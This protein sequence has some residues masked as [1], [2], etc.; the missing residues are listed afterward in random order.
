MSPGVRIPTGADSALQFGG[1]LETY[2][3]FNFNRP[4]NGITEFRAFDNRHNTFAL[5]AA[6][7]DIGWS[8]RSVAARLVLQA[9][10][11][12]DTYYAASEPT[13]AG[14]ALTP[15]ST[16]AAIRFIQQATL[17]WSPVPRRWTVDAGLFLSPIG[18]ESMPTHQ[19]FT[20]S[21]SV[22]FFALPFYHAGARVQWS[23]SPA[24]ALRL[25]VY[26]GWNNA[27]DNNR[28]KTLG[29]D[30][31]YTPSTTVSLGAAYFS[32]VERPTGAPEG[33]AWRHLLDVFVLW[34]PVERVHLL[35]DADVG[36]E[37]NTFGFSGWA[38]GNGA[39]RA[40]LTSWLYTAVRATVFAE[41]RASKNGVSAAPIAIPAGRIASGSLTLEA[42]PE[43]QVSF[44]LELRRD[45]ASSP[46]YFRGAVAGDG[47]MNNPYVPDARGQTTLTLGGTAWF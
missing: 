42:R 16:P 1:Y 38:A 39:A 46:V 2:Y 10:T 35:L 30:Y 36:A 14:T 23:P 22:L 27:L 44:K 21:H 40:R 45:S 34:Q 11:A 15:R 3:S 25:G 7:A 37:P 26:N 29:L 33:R 47:S 41:R 31:L 19:N 13:L 9:G 8:N 18:P 5:Q 4:S 17:A 20:W 12:P 32:G 6:V 43:K 28:E 24:H